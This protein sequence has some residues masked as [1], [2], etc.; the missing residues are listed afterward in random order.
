MSAKVY[1]ETSV[2]SYLAS[3]PSRDLVIA[4]NQQITQEWWQERRLQFEL[5]ISQ[6][7]IQEASAGDASAVELRTQVLGE[8]PLLA[9]TENAVKLSERL[10]R[11]GAM[12]MRGSRTLCTL[13]L[14]L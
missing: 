2:I 8:I 3:R 12:P 6:L 5:Y 9:V 14:Q 13:Q 1:I 11:R 7:V 4:A 10:V